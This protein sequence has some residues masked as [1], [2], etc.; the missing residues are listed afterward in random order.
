VAYCNFQLPKELE[1]FR[2]KVREFITQ[3]VLP[4]EKTLEPDAVGLPDGELKK[5]Q[6]KAKEA[7]LWALGV[8]KKFGG[9]EKSI[10]EL[11]LCSEEAS[12]HR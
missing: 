4:L 3:E 10:F 7:G 6:A 12:Q 2:L 11:T 5:L 8:P 9:Q 1:D